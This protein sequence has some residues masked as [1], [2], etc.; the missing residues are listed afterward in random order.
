MRVGF[1]HTV[2][3]KTGVK[4]ALSMVIGEVVIHY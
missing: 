3:S 4:R 1:D 2:I